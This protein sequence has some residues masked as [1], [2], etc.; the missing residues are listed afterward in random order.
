MR[1][2]F[3][4]MTDAGWK[5][6]MDSTWQKFGRWVHIFISVA[7]I[8]A[9]SGCGSISL[10]NAS[11]DVH[12]DDKDR[13]LYGKN[14][15]T[16]PDDK[17]DWFLVDL[18]K[19]YGLMALF[20]TTVYRYDLPKSQRDDLGCAYLKDGSL[21][22]RNFGMPSN[23]GFGAKGERWERWTPTRED[24]KYDNPPP[25]LDDKESGLF[26]ETYVHRDSTENIVEAVIAYRGTEN[27]SGQMFKDWGA[28]FANFIGV[29]PL[30]YEIARKYVQKLTEYLI[31]DNG[32]KRMPIYAV[33]HSLGGGLAQ[34]AG[35]LSK[36]ITEVYAFNTSPVTNWT[37]LRLAG[38]VEQG[39]PIIHRLYQGGEA[40]AGIR[41][42]AT[43]STGARYGRH[44]VGV[45][46]GPKQL[47]AGHLMY[48]LTCNFAKILVETDAQD[49]AHY[50]PTSYII[51]HVLTP[52]HEDDETAKVRRKSD[53]RVCDE[54][55]TD[56]T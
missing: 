22:D 7:L 19:K 5:K 55:N 40:L 35:Y 26:Y 46:F 56:G 2:T 21:G 53:R 28:D 24:S 43:A 3:A 38:L 37:N 11:M 14:N 6:N 44:D 49:A 51:Q 48:V 31:R 36:N 34:Q 1:I 17:D 4:N 54:N 20:A 8:T 16:K 18:S 47:V 33:G 13:N 10:F 52:Y 29:E 12:S 27:R 9:T 41:A 39:Y 50:Y 30:Q 23:S 25:C 15:V 42:V 45:Q 32:N